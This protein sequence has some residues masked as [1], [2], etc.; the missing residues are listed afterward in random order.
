MD[1]P[2]GQ[3]KGTALSALP[4]E[5]FAWLCALDLREP[6]KSAVHDEVHRRLSSQPVVPE[7]PLP[8]PQEIAALAHDLI[9]AGLLSLAPTSDPTQLN[10]ATDWLRRSLHRKDTPR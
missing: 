8:V 4:G 6:L 1:M 9:S 5:Y 10:Q 3:H 7:P 2:F